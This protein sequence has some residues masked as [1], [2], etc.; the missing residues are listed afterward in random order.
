MVK[1][2]INAMNKFA[3]KKKVLNMSLSEKVKAQTNENVS[4]MTR[5]IGKMVIST[6]GSDKTAT[7]FLYQI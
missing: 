2:W 4:E 5:P 1:W 3:T 6:V 7:P